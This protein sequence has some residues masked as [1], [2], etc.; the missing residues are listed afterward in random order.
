MPVAHGAAVRYPSRMITFYGYKGCSTCVKAAK[1]L[2]EHR[3]AF[4]ERAIRETPPP[5]EAL[6]AMLKARGGEIRALFN[7]SGAD[8]RALGLG[9]KIGTMT[10]DELLRLLASNGNLVKRPFVLDAG[11]GVFLLGFKEAE[12]RLAL[13]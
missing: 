9:A 11:R 8:Y 10:R 7:T 5:H 13:T 12:W 1:W 6:E 3:I 2:R 4:E